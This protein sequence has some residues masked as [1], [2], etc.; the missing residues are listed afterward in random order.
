LGTVAALARAWGGAASPVYLVACELEI[1]G[2]ED[3]VMGLSPPAAAAIEPAITPVQAV[4]R[5]LQTET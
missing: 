3:G 2:G 1:L 5:R 4:E